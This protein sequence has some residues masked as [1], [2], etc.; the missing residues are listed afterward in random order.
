[1][2]DPTS[3][4]CLR[5]PSTVSVSGTGSLPRR[6]VLAPVTPMVTV[7]QCPTVSSRAQRPPRP[8]SP[9]VTH[10][11]S[12]RLCLHPGVSRPPAPQRVSPRSAPGPAAPPRLGRR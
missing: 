4:L 10:T 6:P 12:P 11:R 1:M 8:L 5:V 3:S 2:N 9:S 7:P